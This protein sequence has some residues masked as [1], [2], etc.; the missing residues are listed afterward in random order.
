MIRK[1]EIDVEDVRQRLLKDYDDAE[2]NAIINLYAQAYGDSGLTAE[3]VLEEILCDSIGKMNAFATESTRSLAGEVGVFLRNV[4]KNVRRQE[5]GGNQSATGDGGVMNS[6]EIFLEESSAFS[7]Q[8]TQW[9]K[10]GKESGRSFILG[11]TGEILQGLGAIES[12]IYINGDKIKTILMEHPEI[13]LDEIKKIPQILND[14]VLILKSRNVGRSGSQNTRMVLY[15]SV[16]GKNGSPVMV[17]FDIRPMENHLVINDMQKVSSAY[18]KTNDAV[19]FVQNSFVMYADKKRATSL[20][21]TIGFQ[22]PIELL[23]GGFTGSITYNKQN[24]NLYGEKFSDVF[25]LNSTGNE[26][27]RE[28]DPVAALEKQVKLLRNQKEYWKSQTKRTD[29]KKADSKAV[30]KLGREILFQYGSSTKLDAFLSDLQWLADEWHNY[31]QNST[32]NGMQD[33]AEEIARTILEGSGVDVNGD[34]AETRKELKAFLKGRPIN[35]TEEK[36]AY[37]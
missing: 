37:F 9:D 29:G 24:V 35:V 8:I 11:S 25:R 17:V 34:M 10:A 30:R 32:M 13:T 2:I 6:R 14:P 26:Y 15:G 5:G 16:K 12:D 18:T 27:S 31:S 21:R 1:G 3:E 7:D 36:T 22:M 4:R 28:M 20:L 23:Q 19:F 33:R